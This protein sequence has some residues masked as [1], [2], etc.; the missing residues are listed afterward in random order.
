MSTVYRSTSGQLSFTYFIYLYM[1][2][3]SV[4]ITIKTFIT[5][6]L[7]YKIDECE[8][9]RELPYWSISLSK[10]P[11]ESDFR[12]LMGKLFYNSAPL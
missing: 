2:K 8:P 10:Y 1:V 3:P 9:N 6:A 12:K 11:S 4:Y 7:F 5:I